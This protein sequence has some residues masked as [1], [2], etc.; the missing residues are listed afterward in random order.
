MINTIIIAEKKHLEECVQAL[1]NSELGRVYFSQDGK[2]RQ[3]L[4]H[5][6]EKRQVLVALDKEESLLGFIWYQEY[7]A[8]HGFPYIHIIAIK[9]EYRGKGIGSEL[10]THFE[11]EVVNNSKVFLLVS[12]FNPK[13][14]KLYEKR[15]YREVGVIPDLYKSGVTEH[16]MMKE[17]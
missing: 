4:S 3:A 6:F 7:G 15:G 13:A 17:L 12:D 8:F 14:K 5:G 2:A 16:L 11:E 10:L 9:D 1:K